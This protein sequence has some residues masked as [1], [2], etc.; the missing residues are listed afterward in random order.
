M[1]DFQ[2]QWQST[3]MDNYG[4]PRIEVAK[5]NGATFVDSEGKEYL[6]LLSGIAVNALGHAHPAIV[7]A[8]TDQV[9]TL[10]HVSNIFASQPPLDLAAKLV[11]LTGWESED[12]RVMFC[13]SGTEANEAAFKLARLT[14]RRRIISTHHGFHGRTM[15]ALAM[16][17]QPDKRA[18]FEPMPAGVEFVPYGDIDFLTKTIESDPL[19]VAAVI[20]E[21]IQG[22]TGV[23]A[24]PEGY[25]AAVRELTSRFDVLLIVDEVQTGIGRTGRWFAHQHEGIVP[26][27]MTLAKGLGGGLP[28]G[29]VVANGRAAKL[30]T[31]GAH[32]TTFGGN[33]ICASAGLAVINTLEEEKLVDRVAEKGKVLARK[34]ASLKHVDHV[35]GRGF[36]LGLVLTDNLAKAAVDAGY[37]RGVILNAPQ[38]N[39]IRVVPPLILSDEEINRA[40]ELIDLCLNDAAEQIAQQAQAQ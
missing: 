16:T 39:V 19:G 21:P 8:V 6:D 15:G 23:V 35:R 12:S 14:G 17:G 38:P 31:P 30:F 24:P 10:G 13:N 22:E 33:P 28:L 26:D 18:P 40:V 34:L 11:D 7:E 4:T 2:Q 27:V 9:Q 3:M 29:A 36:M 5:G 32:G 25:F 1:S 20:L 37:E